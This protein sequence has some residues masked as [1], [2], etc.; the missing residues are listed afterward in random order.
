M[1]PKLESAETLRTLAP[2]VGGMKGLHVL[3]KES[4]MDFAYGTLSRYISGGVQFDSKVFSDL[5]KTIKEGKSFTSREA[6]RN[7]EDTYIVLNELV[8]QGVIIPKKIGEAGELDKD[9]EKKQ[10]LTKEEIKDMEEEFGVKLSTEQKEVL[11]GKRKILPKSSRSVDDLFDDDEEEVIEFV[12]NS[13]AEV[14]IHPTVEEAKE[15]LEKHE[16]Y[17]SEPEEETKPEK[18]ELDESEPVEE[19]KS[20][21]KNFLEDFLNDASNEPP[22]PQATLTDDPFESGLRK[23]QDVFSKEEHRF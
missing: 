14:L 8:G 18:H 15:F 22:P 9:W 12:R 10:T 5:F 20:E 7:L 13:K 2:I 4:G 19:T 16:L 6:M 11:Q 17:E 23:T 1:I 3:F 21:K